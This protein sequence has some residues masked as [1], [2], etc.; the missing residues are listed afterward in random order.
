MNKINRILAPY[1][2]NSVQ[3]QLPSRSLTRYP[4]YEQKVAKTKL[5][6]LRDLLFDSPPCLFPRTLPR[7]VKCRKRRATRAS[8]YAASSRRWAE[9]RLRLA[10]I[11]PQNIP[12]NRHT[13]N[14][15][16][17]GRQYTQVTD[18]IHTNQVET[19]TGKMCFR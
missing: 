1:F 14:C 9:R 2:V 5:R 13:G 15:R 7:S 8:F 17:N 16:G 10:K 11:K 3:S 12:V 18:G 6:Y 19:N 4:T